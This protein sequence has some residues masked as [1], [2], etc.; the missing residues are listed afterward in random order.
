MSEYTLEEIVLAYTALTL[1][2]M[3][4]VDLQKSVAVTAAFFVRKDENL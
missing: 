4:I 2:L 3:S 1:L